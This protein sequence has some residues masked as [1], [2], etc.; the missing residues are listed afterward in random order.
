MKKENYPGIYFF[1]VMAFVMADNYAN[2]QLLM[3]T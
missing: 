3:T 1:V 2:A